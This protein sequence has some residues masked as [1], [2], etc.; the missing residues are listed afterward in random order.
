MGGADLRGANLKWANL[1]RTQLRRANLSGAN[2]SGADLTGADLSGAEL[3]GAN[4]EGIKLTGAVMP[5]G[6]L[7]G[8]VRIEAEP[9]VEAAEPV[10]VTPESEAPAESSATVMTGSASLDQFLT[11]PTGSSALE[12]EIQRVASSNG[13]HYTNLTRLL[14]N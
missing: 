8:M 9:V 2:L 7:Y 14:L 4:L 12:G 3:Q 10:T 5:D 1:T 11:E 13:K 6:T